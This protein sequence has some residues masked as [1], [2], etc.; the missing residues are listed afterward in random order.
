MLLKD[1]TIFKAIEE[2]EKKTRADNGGNSKLEINH[3]TDKTKDKLYDNL[4][5][6]SRKNIADGEACDVS[7]IKP[8]SNLI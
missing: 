4:L 1:W 2:A 3:L 8:P 5:S 6:D 7:K